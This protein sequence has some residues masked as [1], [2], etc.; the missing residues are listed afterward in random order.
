MIVITIR[1][2]AEKKSDSAPV[3][4]SDHSAQGVNVELKNTQIGR[5][6]VAALRPGES[7]E[8]RLR[9]DACGVIELRLLGWR[10]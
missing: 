4:T 5:D 2:E 9:L 8:H 6:F 7:V 1:M 3:A 10:K